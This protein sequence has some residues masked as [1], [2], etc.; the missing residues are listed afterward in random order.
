MSDTELNN[1]VNEYFENKPTKT[2]LFGLYEVI[3]EAMQKYEQAVQIISERSAKDKPNEASIPGRKELT[4]TLPTIRLSEKMWGKEGTRDREILQNLLGKI[5]GQGKTVAD[6]IR[7]LNDFLAEEHDKAELT[8]AEILTY[9]VFLDT[10]TNIMLH[11]NASAAGFT[12]EGFL[13]AL[14]EGE[15]VPAGTAEGIQDILDNEKNPLSL[16]LLTGEGSGDVHG[17]YRDLISHFTPERAAQPKFLDPDPDTGEAKPNPRYVGKAGAAG[18]MK[19]LIGLKNWREKDMAGND[20]K[21]G[22]N[23]GEIKF[24]EFSF[25]AETFLKAISTGPT[26][27]HDLLLLPAK[28]MQDQQPEEQASSPQDEP[29]RLT[30]DQYYQMFDK[31]RNLYDRVRNQFTPQAFAE[32]MDT[33]ELQPLVYPQTQTVKDAETGKP[34]KIPHPRAG[35]AQTWGGGRHRGKPKLTLVKKGS[36]P[37]ASIPTVRAISQA[38]ADP[39]YAKVAAMGATDDW[40]SFGESWKLLTNAHGKSDE[41]FWTLVQQTKGAVAGKVSEP[42]S[43]KALKPT[44]AP[45]PAQDELS[46]ARSAK[47]GDEEDKAQSQFVVASRYYKQEYDSDTGVGFLGGIRVGKA[48]VTELANKYADVLNQ[49]IFDIF[50]QLEELSDA[51]NSYFVGGNKDSALEA[52]R[53]AGRIEGRTRRYEKEMSDQEIQPD[54]QAA[55]KE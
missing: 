1:I 9:I 51:L 21:G 52:A 54:L 28:L 23:E 5:I 32:F 20:N 44:P 47:K 3:S 33:H 55:A 12:F 7:L 50:A 40:L 2:S 48:V 29:V 27:N 10:L 43:G 37:G 30:D 41:A 42:E 22:W 14:L 17:S 8:S 25:T 15:Q 24:Y 19:Y 26:S 18:E 39:R 36:E 11:F 49:K 34:K 46:E 53:A 31:A 13:A 16:K 6:K 4:V 45:V 35:E 38:G